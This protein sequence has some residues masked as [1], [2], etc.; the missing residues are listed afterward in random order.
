MG[1]FDVF[2]LHPL[3]TPPLARLPAR[4]IN[5]AGP[6]LGLEV[7]ATLPLRYFSSSEGDGEDSNGGG[8]SKFPGITHWVLADVQSQVNSRELAAEHMLVTLLRDLL[9]RCLGQEHASA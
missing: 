2:P 7:L 5:P 9:Q 1:R 3:I 6:E 8:G 4:P